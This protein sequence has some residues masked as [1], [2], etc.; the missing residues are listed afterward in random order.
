MSVCFFLRPNSV[1]LRV[2]VSRKKRKEREL[3]KSS[4]TA[5][6]VAAL[7]IGKNAR[8]SLSTFHSLTSPE[9]RRRTRTT[10]SHFHTIKN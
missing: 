1:I 7:K 2:V 9:K 6:A 10:G 3:F 8:L 5:T 4:T